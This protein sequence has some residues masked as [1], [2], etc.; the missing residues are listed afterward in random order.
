MVRAPAGDRPRLARGSVQLTGIWA[1]PS[2]GPVPRPELFPKAVPGRAR[3]TPMELLGWLF[4]ALEFPVG[5]VLVTGTSIVPTPEL[6]LAPG[7]VVAIA[8]P[9]VGRLV[10]RVEVVGAA[11]PR[12]E[13][14]VRR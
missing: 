11:R 7:D 1:L 3:G 14:V 8:V 5:G 12:V 2:A 13:E 10:N 4:Q 9:G 6:T